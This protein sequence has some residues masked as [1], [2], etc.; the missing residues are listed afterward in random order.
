MRAHKRGL[1]RG[2]EVL[3]ADHDQDG[4]LQSNPPSNI[5]RTNGLDKE[6]QRLLMDEAV[7]L[8]NLLDE[9]LDLLNNK[10]NR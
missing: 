7:N 8:K 10:E 5:N 9:L 4:T 1:G 6:Q 2:L 3:L